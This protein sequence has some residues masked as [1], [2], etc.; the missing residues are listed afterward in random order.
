MELIYKCP[1]CQE[2]LELLEKSFVCKR[3]HSFDIAREGYV[4]L[5]PANQKNSKDPGDSKEM[6]ESRKLFLEKGFYNEL[7]DTINAILLKLIKKQD[8]EPI[9]V[10]DVGCGV[11]FYGGRLIEKLNN[12]EDKVTLWGIDISKPAVQKAAKKYSGV[13]WAIGSSFHLPYLDHSIDIIFSI[14]APFD[15]REILRVLKPGGKLL[16]VRP[17]PKHLKELAELI[18]DKF[19]LQGNSDEWLKE[20][21]FAKV[22]KSEVSFEMA[23]ENSQDVMNLIN[24][25]PY[26]WHLNNEKKALLA[27]I[28]TLKVAADFSI[29]LCL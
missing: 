26:G 19:Q 1:V 3:N 28:S 10:L 24:M 4:N 18:Y 15:A 2:K 22:E 13:Q 14:F 20:L 21:N 7:S 11:G 27:G 17:G 12:P 16:V 5:L 9:N 25:T 23:L 29:T 6:A 8:G